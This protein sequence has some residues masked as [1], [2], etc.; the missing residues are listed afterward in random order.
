MGKAI[1]SPLTESAYIKRTYNL[2]NGDGGVDNCLEIIYSILLPG[3]LLSAGECR[4]PSQ[5]G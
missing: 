5:G 3:F 4:L 1:S 2:E